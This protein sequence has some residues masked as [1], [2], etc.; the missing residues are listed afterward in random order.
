MSRE[1]GK[2]ASLLDRLHPDP[3]VP[4]APAPDRIRRDLEEL[5]NARKPWLQLPADRKP[6][7]G[8]ILQLGLPHLTELSLEFQMDER[9]LVEIIGALL[10]QF[11]P[12]LASPHIGLDADPVRPT[13]ICIRVRAAVRGADRGEAVDLDARLLPERNRF[14]VNAH[15]RSRH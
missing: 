5:L 10:R 2:P 15:H 8:D 12:R 13:G 1:Y 4:Q 3:S 14:A 7:E 11:E 9:R 6:A